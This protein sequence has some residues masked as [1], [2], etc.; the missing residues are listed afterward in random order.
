MASGSSVYR[1]SGS[2]RFSSNESGKA[3]KIRLPIRPVG[4]HG[5]CVFRRIYLTIR[6][7]SGFGFF[8]TPI[9][10]GLRRTDLK[11]FFSRSSPAGGTEE[12][13]DFLFPLPGLR[14][15]ILE[16]EL[17]APAPESRAWW[18]PITVAVIPLSGS[19]ART[20]GE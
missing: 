12:R 3:A 5:E 8:A 17:E 6:H 18:E 19:R 9:I 10:D 15:T 20:E 2:T 7:E 14:G 13:Y 4:K 16:L 1:A 11:R